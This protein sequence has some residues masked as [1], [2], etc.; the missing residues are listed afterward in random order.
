[1][2]LIGRKCK[3]D[4]PAF[5]QYFPEEKGSGF[6]LGFGIDYELDGGQAVHASIALVERELDGQ[7]LSI[8]IKYVQFIKEESK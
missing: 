4:K 2:E 1:M 8:P 7:I 3:W 6:F 5:R